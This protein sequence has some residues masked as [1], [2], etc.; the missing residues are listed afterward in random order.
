MVK[1]GGVDDTFIGLV[2]ADAA[3][4]RLRERRDV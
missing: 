2:A 4:V 1:K 3:D